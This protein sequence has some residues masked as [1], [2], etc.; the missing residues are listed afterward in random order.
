MAQCVRADRGDCRGVGCRV[1]GLRM[2]EVPLG[3]LFTSSRN[4]VTLEG[5]SL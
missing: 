1:V 4:W 3:E 5:K 2:K